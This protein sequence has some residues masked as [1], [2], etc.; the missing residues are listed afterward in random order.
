LLGDHS[1]ETWDIII[2]GPLL[3][4]SKMQ[5]KGENIMEAGKALEEKGGEKHIVRV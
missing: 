4:M 3:C 5:L 2:I 1:I